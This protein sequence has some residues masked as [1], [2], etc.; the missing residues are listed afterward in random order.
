MP[1]TYSAAFTDLEAIRNIAETHGFCLIKNVFSP[2]EIHR[3][4][5]GLANDHAAFGGALPE[6]MSC[7]SLR[8]AA[9]DKRILSVAR[10]LLPE[11]LYYYGESHLD[12]ENEIG[13][14]T[15]NPFS[16]PHIDARGSRD[17]LKPFW[18]SETDALFRG[19]RFAIYLQDYKN[20]SG[21]LLVA[22]GSHK[23]SLERLGIGAP[24]PATTLALKIGAHTFNIS[25][26]ETPLY[27][28]PSEPGDLVVWNLRTLHSAGARR[29]AAKPDLAMLPVFEDEIAKAIP[30]AFLPQPGPRNAIFFDYGT[31]A[32]E[33]DLYIKYRSLQVD[34][35]R[36][37][38][39]KDWSYDEPAVQDLLEA[40]NINVRFDPIIASLCV[41]IDM[42]KNEG[43][44]E[45]VIAKVRS[46]L[47]PLLK[48][49][50]EFSPYFSLFSAQTFDDMAREDE[51]AAANYAIDSVIAQNNA[52]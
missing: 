22:D 17:S 14:R 41:Q 42:L 35:D 44:E 40:E 16:K 18:S 38:Q 47:F 29:L 19:Y 50:K 51:G 21:G 10:T 31:G 30:N 43:A 6:I 11:P 5:E 32:E 34:Q 23:G 1:E 26:P 36:L 3:L 49:H 24:A 28:I 15:L 8:W 33:V 37:V 4:S 7:P 27:I 45:S 46:R 12:F 2:E 20:W 13:P 25:Q 52:A 39:T 9:L 48:Q